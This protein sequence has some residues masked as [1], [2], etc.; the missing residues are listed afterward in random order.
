M[1]EI[2]HGLRNMIRRYDCISSE[3]GDLKVLFFF[4][5]FYDDDDKT[6]YS[7]LIFCIPKTRVIYDRRRSL[8]TTEE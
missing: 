4:F 3:I 7:P 6:T 1:H 5:Y 2:T 8:I